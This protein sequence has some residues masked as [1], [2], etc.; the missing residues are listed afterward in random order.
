VD[1]SVG[2]SKHFQRPRRAAVEAYRGFRVGDQR[3]VRGR[4]ESSPKAGLEG[5]A[6]Y[7]LS[8]RCCATPIEATRREP[9]CHSRVASGHDRCGH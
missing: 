2:W 9:R 4:S 6:I 1:F 8:R 5:G 3:L 7:A